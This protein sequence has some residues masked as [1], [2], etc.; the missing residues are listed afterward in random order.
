MT[1]TIKI[2][3]HKEPAWPDYLRRYS[4]IGEM[5]RAKQVIVEIGSL[6]QQNAHP[7]FATLPEALRRLL[8]FAK[9]DVVICLDD[10]VSP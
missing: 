5:E 3:H 1:P 4:V 9:P 10:G 8:F 6:P 2:Y 7:E